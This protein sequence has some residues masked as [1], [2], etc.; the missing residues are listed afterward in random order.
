MS[1]VSE[2]IVREY[3]ES[4][5]FLVRQQ[6]KSAPNSRR[7]AAEVDFWVLN[8]DRPS[9]TATLPPILSSTDLPQIAR[10]IVIVRAW[11][12]ETFGP[13]VLARQ[14]DLARMLT[15][16]ALRKAARAFDGDGPLAK[17]LVVSALPQGE[18]AR[19]KSIE[20]L[21]SKGIDSVIPFKIMLA[22][23]VQ[24]TEVN[25]NYQKS[26]LL[27]LIRVFKNYDLFKS[28]QMELFQD[29]RGSK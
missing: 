4:H 27:Q 18:A 22:D 3:F 19:A 20:L 13:G 24:S 11:H 16:T 15:A 5:R 10:A 9:G 14:T 17:I 26:D 28:A 2:T 7:E 21:R 6:R 29:Q 1:S 23:L 8:P 12:S 25:R